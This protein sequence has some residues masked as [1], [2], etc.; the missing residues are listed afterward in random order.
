MMEMLQT[1]WTALTTENPLIITLIS[2]PLIFIE[3]YISMLLFTTILNIK[4][5][6]NE[7]R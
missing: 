2:I 5:T 6:N 1:I 3:V 7:S 4:T